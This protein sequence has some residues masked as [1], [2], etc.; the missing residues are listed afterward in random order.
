[1]RHDFTGQVV[2]VTGGTQGIGRALVEQL[3]A[4]KAARIY[5]TGRQPQ[6][7]GALG[8]LPNVVALRSDVAQ[9]HE[10]EQ[11]IARITQDGGRLDLLI[12]NAGIQTYP[13]FLDGPDLEQMRQEIAINL[14]A[15]VALCALAIPLLRK[16]KRAAIINV[17]SGLAFAP[18]QAAPVYCAT[19]AGLRS[20]SQALRYQ[21]EGS[22]I[23]VATVYPPVVKTAMTEG[24]NDGAMTAEQAAAELLKAFAAGS[25]E[26]LIG[27]AKLLPFLQRV[28]P[29]FVARRLRGPHRR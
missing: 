5:A 9:P 16:G 10:R 21:L 18:K 13:D 4:Y 20:F 6:L 15:P 26:I 22:G 25:D 19:K 23:R 1:M 3:A 28:A 17:S 14:E 7:L 11:L 27:Q 12:N 24:R 2:L 8:N 29:G